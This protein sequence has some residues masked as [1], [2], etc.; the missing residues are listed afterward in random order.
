MWTRLPSLKHKLTVRM[1]TKGTNLQRLC[2]LERQTQHRHCQ[3]HSQKDPQSQTPYRW[4]CNDDLWNTVLAKKKPG[5]IDYDAFTKQRIQ[6]LCNSLITRRN[7]SI[8]RRGMRVSRMEPAMPVRFEKEAGGT[9][10][11]IPQKE[12]YHTRT[13]RSRSS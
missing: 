7:L 2:S 9:T 13:Q 4:H 1:L 8:L 3:L 5:D 11:E 12:C 6:S 10:D